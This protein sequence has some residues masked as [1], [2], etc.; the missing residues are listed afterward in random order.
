MDAGAKYASPISR[1]RHMLP[2]HTCDIMTSHNMTSCMG[3]RCHE[4]DDSK[5]A[6]ATAVNC[7][8]IAQSGIPRLGSEQECLVCW[9]HSSGDFKLGRGTGALGA[10]VWTKLSGQCGCMQQ[11]QLLL[12]AS[13]AR[14]WMG[15]LGSQ[16]Y[17]LSRPRQLV[18]QVPGIPVHFLSRR[19]HGL[20]LAPPPPKPGHWRVS[21]WLQLKPGEAC[22]AR[23]SP[24]SKENTYVL[25][26]GRVLPA[27]T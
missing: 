8:A 21:L 25:H 9:L 3:L 10:A 6:Q 19:G 12:Y 24:T 1:A 18:H 13:Q 2:P 14:K 26:R 15:H 16:Y 27:S 20:L 23:Q 4:L 17:G 5:I 11:V 22:R 7:R